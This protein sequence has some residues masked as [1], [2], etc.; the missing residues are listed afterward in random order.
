MNAHVCA[1]LSFEPCPARIAW[2]DGPGWLAALLVVMWGGFFVMAW[3]E[4]AR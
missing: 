4:R 2:G 1:L 3:R